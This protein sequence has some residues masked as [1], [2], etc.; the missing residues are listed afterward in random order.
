MEFDSINKF[1]NQVDKQ[2][3]SGNRSGSSSETRPAEQVSQKDEQ[4]KAQQTEQKSQQDE[5]PVRTE[6]VG[7]DSDAPK[8][9]PVSDVVETNEPEKDEQNAPPVTA[10]SDET[11]RAD[12]NITE[13]KGL[14]RVPRKGSDAPMPSRDYSDDMFG[15][16]VYYGEDLSYHLNDISK[17]MRPYLSEALFKGAKSYLTYTK[18]NLIARMNQGQ[19][20]AYVLI[21]TFPSEIKRVIIDEMADGNDIVVQQLKEDEIR[22]ASPATLANIASNVQEINDQIRLMLDADLSRDESMSAYFPAILYAVTWLLTDRMD[23]REKVSAR[24]SFNEYLNGEQTIPPNVD[25]VLR[26][27]EGLQK[28]LDAKNN[29]ARSGNIFRKNAGIRGGK[30]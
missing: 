7:L 27:G 3:L 2:T 10:A 16:L 26:A 29:D 5:Q 9:Q 6:N 18:G 23:L 11:S 17:T 19:F 12:N 15:G 22:E 4:I 30:L 20:L 14:D 1:K 25:S 24:L 21:R 28:R 8:E 13:G